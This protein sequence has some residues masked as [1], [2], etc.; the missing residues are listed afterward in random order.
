MFSGLPGNEHTLAATDL[1]LCATRVGGFGTEVEWAHGSMMGDGVVFRKVVGPVAFAFV[2]V[3]FE[4]GLGGSV[5]EPESSACPL[6]WI[7]AAP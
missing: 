2:P 6:L 1:G 5:L 3:V 7:C 4:L